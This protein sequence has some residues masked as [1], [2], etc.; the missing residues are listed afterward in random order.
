MRVSI[1]LLVATHAHTCVSMFWIVG[2]VLLF[3]VSVIVL[4][5][6]Q[7]ETMLNVFGLG[8]HLASQWLLLTFFVIGATAVEYVQKMIIEHLAYYD[9]YHRLLEK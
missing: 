7:P 6:L 2:S 4:Q 8:T 9:A 1:K 3:Y 5:L